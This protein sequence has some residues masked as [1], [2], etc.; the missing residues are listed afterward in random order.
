MA[1]NKKGRIDIRVTEVEREAIRR[2]AAQKGMNITSYL[3]MKGM[4]EDNV[5]YTKP[6]KKL[7]QSINT[8]YFMIDKICGDKDNPEVLE[9]KERI[10]KLWQSLK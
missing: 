1:E 5:L 7:L 8:L 4:E 9:V 6:V 3:V 10:E 2:K